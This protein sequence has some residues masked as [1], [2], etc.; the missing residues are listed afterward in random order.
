MTYVYELEAHFPIRI[1]KNDQKRHLAKTTKKHFS[2]PRRFYKDN[3]ILIATQP[4]NTKKTKDNL[5]LQPKARAS[6]QKER[7]HNS[8]SENS[9]SQAK[10]EASTENPCS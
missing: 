9:K 6:G 5:G 1:K 4:I 3:Y 8:T 7:A 10:I 2:K